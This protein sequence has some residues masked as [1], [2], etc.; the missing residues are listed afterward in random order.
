MVFGVDYRK[1]PSR[2]DYFDYRLESQSL[3]P[4]LIIHSNGTKSPTITDVRT[5]IFNQ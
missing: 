4:G 2:E 1:F 3:V 5:R